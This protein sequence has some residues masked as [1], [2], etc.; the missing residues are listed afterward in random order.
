MPALAALIRSAD[1][2]VLDRLDA[3]PGA[4]AFR[5]KLEALMRL[6]GDRTGHGWGSEA[7]IR[8]PT[9]REQPAEPLN[10]VALYLDSSLEPPAEARRRARQIRDDEVE[11]LCAACG[12]GEVVLAFRRELAQARRVVTVLEE[13]NHYIDQLSSGQLRRAVM[14]AAGWLVAHGALSSRDEILWLSFDEILAALRA[15]PPASQTARVAARRAQHAEWERLDAPPILGVPDAR[16]PERPPSQDEVDEEQTVGPGQVRGLGGSAGR[17]R[18]RARVV[19]DA[20]ALPT[21]EKGDVLV[22]EN[23]GPRWTPLFPLLG[24]LILDGGSPGQHAAA[25]ARKYCIP[26]VIATGDATRRIPDGSWVTLDGTTGL[27]ERDDGC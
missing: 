4:E 12:D 15:N 10:L 22:A 24:G 27:V 1:P 8:T 11:A 20:L 26:A 25:T 7:T 14:A 13:H 5:I 21:I 6:Y 19:V 9:W 18:G 2:A 3:I 16:L 17:A 23:V